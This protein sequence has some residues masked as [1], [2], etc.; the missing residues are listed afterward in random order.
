MYI[1]AKKHKL[2]IYT[3]KVRFFNKM[4][5]FIQK[6]SENLD[7]KTVIIIILFIACGV[8]GLLYYLTP[9]G[10][11]D[12]RDE[13][14]KQKTELENEKR[15]LQKEYNKILKKSEQ[16]SIALQDQMREFQNLEIRYEE[17]ERQLRISK[18]KAREQRQRLEESKREVERIKNRKPK[19]GQDLLDSVKENATNEKNNKEE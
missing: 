11:E 8:L 4:K 13:F 3:T 16:D 6:T 15:D 2:L 5:E 9:S 1:S 10:G 17:A 18:D 7:I 19:E 12:L 14:E